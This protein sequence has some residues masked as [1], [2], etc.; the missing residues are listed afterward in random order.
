MSGFLRPEAARVLHRWREVLVALAVVLLGLW[1][2]LN[3]GPVVRG[4]GYVLVAIGALGAIPAIRRARF[5][6]AGE[7]PGV[8]QVV[9]G[10][11]TYMGPVTGGAIALG[12]MTALSLRHE[13]DGGQTWVL[14][15]P[16]ETLDIPAN[17]RGAEA[18]FDAFVTL[19]GMSAPHLLRAQAARSPGQQRLW[20]RARGTNRALPP[21]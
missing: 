8:V 21:S 6:T 16:G 12:E 11:I 15:Q 3:P 14:E 5:G 17:A 9:E 13:P 10:R 2:A 4:F 7:G 19:D 20:T 18:L 1:I